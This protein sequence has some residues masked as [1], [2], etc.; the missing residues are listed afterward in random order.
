MTGRTYSAKCVLTRNLRIFYGSHLLLY[1]CSGFFHVVKRVNVVLLFFLY[2]KRKSAFVHKP[3]TG[4]GPLAL[5]PQRKS[6]CY[7]SSRTLHCRVFWFRFMFIT[8]NI[9]LYF[10]LLAC[11]ALKR[12]LM[13]GAE[14]HFLMV[15]FS[16]TKAH[17]TFLI[18]QL[19]NRTRTGFPLFWRIPKTLNHNNKSPLALVAF[20][21]VDHPICL[22]VTH[23]QV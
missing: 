23:T 16:Y 22:Q 15:N 20:S 12:I 18:I 7:L 3:L 4:L 11:L 17:T 14:G 1:H 21:F 8:C 10:V 6:V 13:K 5:L 2:N 19:L 9:F